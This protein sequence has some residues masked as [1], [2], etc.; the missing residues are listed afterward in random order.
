MVLA[1][2]KLKAGEY[3]YVRDEIKRVH[4]VCK[5]FGKIL[6]VIIEIYPLISFPYILNTQLLSNRRRDY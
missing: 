2:G 5:E 6:K 3:D 4:D 1:I